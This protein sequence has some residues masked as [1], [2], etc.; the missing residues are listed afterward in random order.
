M[1][2]NPDFSIRIAT[3]NDLNGDVGARHCQVHQSHELI[4]ILDN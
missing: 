3:W 4:I 2:Q 1:E